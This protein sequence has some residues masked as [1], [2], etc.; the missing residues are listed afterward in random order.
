M[1]SCQ[2][3]RQLGRRFVGM[4]PATC[5]EPAVWETATGVTEGWTWCDGH[6]TQSRLLHELELVTL[7]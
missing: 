3:G 5:P 1:K 2:S 7:I 4:R 6:V